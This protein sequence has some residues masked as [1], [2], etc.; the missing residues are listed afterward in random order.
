MNFTISPPTEKLYNDMFFAIKS[1]LMKDYIEYSKIIINI[2]VEY[3]IKI[4]YRA[5]V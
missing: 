1:N 3:H 5:H 4:L 2:F